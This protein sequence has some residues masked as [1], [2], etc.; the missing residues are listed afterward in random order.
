M[1]KI[2]KGQIG[3]QIPGIISSDMFKKIG[4]GLGVSEKLQNWDRTKGAFEP[5]F[6]TEDKRLK[7]ETAKPA[8]A[9]KL[10]SNAGINAANAKFGDAFSTATLALNNINTSLVGNETTGKTAESLNNL[11][12]I[13][14]SVAS[15]FNPLGGM[16]NSV[17]KTIGNLI[18]GTK[19][20]VSGSGSAAVSAVSTGLS[21][22]GPVGNLIGAG[23]NLL[24]GIGGGRAM[25]LADQSSEFGSGFSGSQSYV[26][27][28]I[29]KY[30]GKKAG[31]FD[32]GFKSNANKKLR[33][34]QRQQGLILDIQDKDKKM[35]LNSAGEYI[36]ANNANLY[37]GYKPQLLLSRSGMK[38]PELDAARNLINSWSVKSEE[39][40]KFQL[41]GKMNLIPE[42]A[43]H[44]RKHN[45]SDTNPD[46]KDQITSKGIPV[47]MQAEGGVTQTA[48]VEKDE[49]TLR[50]EFT[51]ELESLYKLYQ[52]DSS[53]E[54]AIKAG[55]LVCY[56]LLKNTDDRS[57]LIKSIK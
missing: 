15:K 8:T 42:G 9:S 4:K 27:N 38:F 30:S 19:D 53:N 22:A 16:V 7:I 17:G 37:A 35:D 48:E 10:F 23:L 11:A 24:N 43:L 39:P 26:H 40:Q 25:K 1:H 52:K 13:G 44:A 33:E 51:D 46:L 57:G 50:K 21:F 41:G 47:V 18:G 14:A 54:A 36:T 45:L 28:T 2:I 5:E 34:A 6:L 32:F 49:W 29:D 20:R 12:N 55:K 31:L 56:E 3:V